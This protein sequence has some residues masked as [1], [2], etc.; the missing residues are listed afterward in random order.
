M[1]FLWATVIPP[2]GMACDLRPE[3]GQV[4]Q[5][6]VGEAPLSRQAAGGYAVKIVGDMEIFRRIVTK[7]YGDH[8]AARD[9]Y[10]R[11]RGRRHLEPSRF[12]VRAEAVATRS[13]RCARVEKTRQR[14][15]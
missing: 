10:N 8:R 7:K 2:K 6:P 1:T 4:G 15:Q 3:Y 12:C 13:S 11:G 9:V 14:L 5:D